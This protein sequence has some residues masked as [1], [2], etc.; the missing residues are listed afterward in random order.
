MTQF[1]NGHYC[2]KLAYVIIQQLNRL[3][4]HPDLDQASGSH[5]MYQQLLGQWQQINMELLQR[6]SEQK[7]LQMQIH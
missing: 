1:I 7:R 4:K 2:P 3:L 6:K 5:E